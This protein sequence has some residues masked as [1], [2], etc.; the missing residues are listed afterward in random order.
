[1]TSK[2]KYRSLFEQDMG[3]VLEAEGFEYEPYKIPYWTPG[4]Y[5]PDFVLGD[6]LV[7]AK[8]YFRPGDTKKYKAIRDALKEEGGSRELVFLLQY[9]GKRVRK[10]TKLTMSDWCEKENIEWFDI[11]EDVVDYANSL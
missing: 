4:N 10:G 9:P 6:I 8:G 11:P 2:R 7:E 1:M 5:T 3:Q